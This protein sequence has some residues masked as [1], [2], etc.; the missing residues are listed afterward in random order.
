MENKNKIIII[1]LIVIIIALLVAIITVMP[2][3]NK[4]DTDL[5]FTSK[6]TLTEGDSI[7]IQLT[8]DNGTAL[9][10]QT[11][12]ITITDKDKT[13]D[14]HSVVTDAK[15]IAKLKLDKNPGKYEI[16]VIYG[17]D[18]N[19][20]SCNATKKITIE[21]KVVEQTQSSSS[22]SSDD[23]VYSPQKGGY[24]KKSG[25]WDK[26]SN[27]NNIYSYQGS[28]GVIYEEYYDSNGNKISSEDY[29]R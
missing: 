14:Y 21:E 28:D 22:S 6:S 13:S 23:Y 25:Q 15:G 17:G 3:L 11:V 26:D 9:A 5:T 27:G 8:D 7:K 24:V 19:Y 1:A 10:N 4:H 29:Y 2:N 12:N 18:D 16:T 20:D